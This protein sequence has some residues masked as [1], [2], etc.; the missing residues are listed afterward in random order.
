MDIMKYTALEKEE[1]ANIQTMAFIAPKGW[2]VV[3]GTY[4]GG[5]AMATR[6]VAPDRKLMVIDSFEGLSELTDEDKCE[7]LMNPG[8][9]NNQGVEQY[10]QNF[11]E[12]GLKLPD[13]IHKMWIND[14]NIRKIQARKIAFLWLDLDLY[15]PTLACLKHFG[16]MIV[17]GGIMMTHDFGFEQTPGIE[18]A[19][20]EYGGEWKRVFANM[21]KQV[22]R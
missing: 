22:K 3:A 12:M 7:K 5:D 19:C 1:I 16:P 9:F 10:K 15:E 6:I 20:K 13:K 18:K 2:I 4:K 17:K 8:D 14:Q 21:F 11:K